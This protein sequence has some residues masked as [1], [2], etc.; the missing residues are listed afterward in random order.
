MLRQS[1]RLGGLR[2]RHFRG[3]IV[4]VLRGHVALLFGAKSL[5]RR[6]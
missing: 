2:G 3:D 5:Q 4:A 6:D 1:L